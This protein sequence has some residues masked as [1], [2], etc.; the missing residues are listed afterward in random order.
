MERERDALIAKGFDG[1]RFG[2]KKKEPRNAA[3]SFPGPG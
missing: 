2:W 1:E 3:E